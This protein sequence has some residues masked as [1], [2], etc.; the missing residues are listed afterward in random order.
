MKKILGFI[1][2]LMLSASLY[3]GGTASDTIVLTPDGTG[4]FIVGQAFFANPDGWQ[5][6]IRVVNTNST[7]TSIVKISFV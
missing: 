7:A 3:A 5:T 4:D 1:S 6:T 2:A